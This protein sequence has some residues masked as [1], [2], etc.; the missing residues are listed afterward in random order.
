MSLRSVVAR[1]VPAR[2]RPWLRRQA[3]R[4]RAPFHRGSAVT[5]PCC[6]GS[7][8]AFLAGG[9]RRREG[10]RCPRCDSLER[11]RLVWLYLLRRTDLL[12]APHRVL[13]V[14]P[15]PQFH[16]RLADRANLDYVSADLASPLARER[17]DVVDIPY[18]DGSFD[19]VICN[20][21]LE[22]VPDD[23]R[24]MRELRRVLAPDGWAVLQTPVHSDREKTL[25]DP[26]VSD[27]SERERLFGQP[28]HVRI[29]GRD[30]FERLE[31]AGFRVTRDRF[32]RELSVEE[33]TRYG[34]RKGEAVTVCTPG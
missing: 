7:F 20:H 9:V 15:E 11:H 34:L 23:A 28:D 3:G 22:H 19:V 13:H 6:G 4:L 5:C 30:F 1:A 8:R 18:P 29:Y 26:A 25:E 27:A 10:V 14:A 21:V 2:L 16:E 31:A 12:S 33:R 24:A 32:A 17:F